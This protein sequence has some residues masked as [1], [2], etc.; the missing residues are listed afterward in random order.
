M[1]VFIVAAGHQL[2]GLVELSLGL[3][4]GSRRRGVLRSKGGPRRLRPGLRQLTL[5]CHHAGQAP[6]R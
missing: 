2:A 4:K 5:D 6:Y 1:Q 3:A